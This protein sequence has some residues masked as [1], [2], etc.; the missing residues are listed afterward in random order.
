MSEVYLSKGQSATTGLGSRLPLIIGVTGHRDLRPQDADALEYNVKHVLRRLTRDYTGEDDNTP[1][2]VMSSLADG[3]DQLVARVAIECGA[4]L[5]APLPM[6]SAEYRRDFENGTGPEVEGEFDRLLA[7]AVSAPEMP[8]V[9]GNTLENI[10]SDPVRRALQYR[11]AGVFIVRHCH[12][13]LALWDGE[14]REL[15]TGGTAEIV[16][17]KRDGTS[18][19][20]SRL[21]HDCIDGAE[22]G[23]I[24]TIMTPRRNSQSSVVQVSVRPWGRELTTMA[25]TE[26]D[27]EGEPKLWRDF[28]LTIALTTRFNKDAKK[29]LSDSVGKEKYKQSLAYLFDAPSAPETTTQ[30]WSIG[31]QDAPLLCAIYAVA[32][33]LAQENQRKFKKIWTSLFVMGF[34]MAASL[35]LPLNFP[36]IKIY[37]FAAYQTLF[38]CSFAL[39]FY[40]RRY[41]HQERYL[42][43][44]ALTETVR[45]GIF[46]RIGMINKAIVEVYPICQSPELSWVGMSLRSL[47]CFDGNRTRRGESL[48][49]TRYRICHDVWIRSQFEYFRKHGELHRKTAAQSER[50]SIL[51]LLVSGVGTLLLGISGYMSFDWK[52]YAPLNSAPFIPLTL[53]LLPLA[54]AAI[55]GYAEQLGRTAQ[56]LQFERMRILF[57]RALAILPDSI[58]PCDEVAV[59][60]VLIEVGREAVQE[61]ASWTSIFRLRPLRP[62]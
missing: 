42:D 36:S 2:V 26:S 58:E 45:V 23:P 59:Q 43:Y 29:I 35:G 51:L 15:K 16:H 4:M 28:E 11:E 8:L 62:M 61:A 18:L 37:A 9:G 7:Y 1:L 56:A 54:G 53:Q 55:Q 12:V 33:I 24:I 41:Q 5:V 60:E 32:D 46:W 20:N 30:A 39:Y 31:F 19:R 21:M 40:A 22:K 52:R 13:L 10:K 57:G 47:T 3:A 38:I 48:N 14:D 44:R 6:G 49:E 25:M 50:F 27:F 34:L 17:L